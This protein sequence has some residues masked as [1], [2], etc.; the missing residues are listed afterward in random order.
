MEMD[1]SLT[2]SMNGMVM[3]SSASTSDSRYDD[4]LGPWLGP[5]MDE[6][7]WELDSFKQVRPLE[8]MWGS[9]ETESG[10]AGADADDDEDDPAAGAGPAC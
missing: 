6:S 2:D 4:P 1:L 5:K 7:G 10:L 8:V 3:S 9:N